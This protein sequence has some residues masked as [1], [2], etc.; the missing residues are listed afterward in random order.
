VRWI[1]VE[2]CATGANGSL[3]R[4][5]HQP[6][7]KTPWFAST[8]CFT[9]TIGTNNTDS[10]VHVDTEIDLVEDDRMFFRIPKVDIRDLHDGPR[11]FRNVCEFQL[12]GVFLGPLDELLDLGRL[13]SDGDGLVLFLLAPGTG[14]ALATLFHGFLR[15]VLGLAL[16]LELPN[17]LLLL[18]VGLECLLEAVCLCLFEAVVVALVGNEFQVFDVEDFLADAVQKVLVV[19]NNKQ[20]LLPGLQV[21][22][23]PD[24]G[25]QIEMVRRFVQHQQRRF[26]KEGTG[27]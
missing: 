13:G 18:L 9:R 14:L 7:D 17:A 8:H 20:G 23:E 4:L 3:F 26:D 5:L 21:I 6:I 2:A 16:S 19:G 10:A 22:V 15:L 25:V 24:D 11:E 27:Q 12:D 1:V